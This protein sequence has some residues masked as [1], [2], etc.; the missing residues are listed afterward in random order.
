MPARQA[1]ERAL[2]DAG[3]RRFAARRS[4]AGPARRPP[5]LPAVLAA[6]DDESREVRL[7]AVRLAGATADERAALP[8]LARLE[9]VDRQIRV[10]AIRA[11]AA[12]PRATPALL[13]IAHEAKDDTGVAAVD[14]LGV[15]KAEAALPL[16]AGLAGRRPADDLVRHAQ[17]AVAR[18]GDGGRGG[19]VGH[20][21]SNATRSGRADRSVARHGRG[22][23]SPVDPRARVRPPNSAAIAA[24]L[25]GEMGDRR[26]TAALCA[27]VDDGRRAA[28]VPIAIDAL[29]R[30]ADPAAVPALARAAESPDLE[31]RRAFA[32]LLEGSDAR[33]VAR[34]RAGLFDPDPHVRRLAANLAGALDA[35]GGRD[36][37]ATLIV[38]RD[39][40]VRR[41]AAAALAQVGAPSSPV[42]A[43][44]VGALFQSGQP[45]GRA[46]MGSG[47]SRGDALERVVDAA[48]GPKLIDALAKAAA[49]PAGARA[50]LAR[51]LAVAFAGRPLADHAAI[52]AADGDVAGRRPGS[53]G[54][55]PTRW[56]R[57]PIARESR[58]ALVRAFAV[59][60]PAVRARLC[61][62][63]GTMPDGGQW[64][65]G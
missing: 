24:G 34:P 64:L 36:P 23:G 40:Q 25:L 31:T 35:R 56:R 46:T 50:A 41:A 42:S 27:V 28:I 48:D 33:A 37:L 47:S 52:R 49:G 3:H 18:A 58:A 11:L 19:R 12:F 44:V 59:A 15:A 1:V 53:A 60:A 51:G 38:D 45:L 4:N 6:L 14:A 39:R 10:E 65:A 2:R 5:E 16:L 30:L 55:P 21:D 13:R 7:R 62:A 54:R 9:D 29:A 8:L 22:G 43:A 20:A 17:N 61:G 57:P 63:L 26:A 32:A